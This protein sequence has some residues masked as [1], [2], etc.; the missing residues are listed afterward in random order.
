MPTASTNIKH[1]IDPGE[2][3]RDPKALHPAWHLA[4]NEEDPDH[5]SNPTRLMIR[6]PPRCPGLANNEE[7]L[8]H[9]SNPIR[10]TVR[11]PPQRLCSLCSRVHA[12]I[13]LRHQNQPT[14][15]LSCQAQ[16][17]CSRCLR[18]KKRKHFHNTRRANELFKSC[19]G[20]R[21][22]DMDC[23]RKHHEAAHALG[24]RWYTNGSHCVTIAACTTADD[25]L[26][27]SCLACLERRRE[28][29]AAHT[30]TAVIDQIS[31][32]DIIDERDGVATEPIVDDDSVIPLKTSFESQSRPM[33]RTQLPLRLA[34]AVTVHKSQG[35]MLPRIRLGL[36]KKEFSCGLT[37]VQVALSHV[38]S[39]DGLLFIEELNWERVKSLGGK[40]L[41]L[42][43]QDLA[44][45]Y[46]R[47]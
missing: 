4:Y 37:F 10:L 20:C 38:T 47:N 30:P 45:R 41:Q 19:Q 29:Y 22:K 43:L 3:F 35:L 16:E 15:C 5:C 11:L 9:R 1:N 40:F 8:E 12:V 32:Q 39:L 6:L 18:L 36:G 13:D 28:A 17:W 21:N 33:A 7:V 46:Q 23:V 26:H 27:A 42:R 31:E 24:L 14:C 44:R 25:V 2:L 34:W